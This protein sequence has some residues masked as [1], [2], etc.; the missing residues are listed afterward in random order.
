MIIIR[1]SGRIHDYLMSWNDAE[2]EIDRGYEDRLMLTKNT[3]IWK[4]KKM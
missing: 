1:A 3:K 4:V 2:E